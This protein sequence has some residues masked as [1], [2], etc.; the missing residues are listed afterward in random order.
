[1]SIAF[2]DVDET[3]I[4]GK[5]MFLFLHRYAEEYP[6]QCGLT[7]A[8]IVRKLQALSKAGQPREAINRYYYSLFRHEPRAQ[9]RAVAEALYREGGYGFHR[10]V[11]AILR[12]H[13]AR[14]DDVVFVS[15]SMTDILWPAMAAL[16]VEHA[17]CSEPVVV[18]EHYTG[19]TLAD[20]HW[21]T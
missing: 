4:T 10:E 20:R 11:V 16:G 19:G 9:V 14:G 13:Q 15:G 17:L 5:S 18:D 12:Q 2:F 7:A 8:A 21:R 3:L 1:M 6:L